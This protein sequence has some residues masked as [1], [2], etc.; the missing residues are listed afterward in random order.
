MN[1]KFNMII[2]LMLLLLIRQA[3]SQN[4][5]LNISESVI[6]KINVIVLNNFIN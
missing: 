4:K 3:I 5:S 6:E 1:L 2:L